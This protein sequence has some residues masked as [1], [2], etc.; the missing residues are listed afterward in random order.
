MK[1][2]RLQRE[3]YNQH[4]ARV[5]RLLLG[6][7]VL[8]ETDEGITSGRIVETEAYK[9]KNDPACHAA[10]GRTNRNATMFGPPG[11]AYVYSIHSRY[12]FN[13]VTQPEGQPSA[14]LVRA[15]EPIDGI[16]IMRARRGLDALRDLARGPARLC[17]ALALSTVHDGWDLTRGD[18]LWIVDDGFSLKPSQIVRVPRIG[19]SSAQDLKLRFLI[20]ANQFV[21]GPKKW[22]DPL[23]RANARGIL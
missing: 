4:V 5:A 19:V 1:T 23:G 6:K 22:L 3:F 16:E 12:C 9:S 7:V 18:Q 21:S 2:Q 11:H 20:R 17:E 13:V 8:R 10:R 15:I 14:V